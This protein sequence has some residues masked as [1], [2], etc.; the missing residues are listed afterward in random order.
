M[1]TD[2]WGG[3]DAFIV[4]NLEDVHKVLDSGLSWRQG[5]GEVLMYSMEENGRLK[6]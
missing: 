2:S 5:T 1:E 6:L 4:A 3:R